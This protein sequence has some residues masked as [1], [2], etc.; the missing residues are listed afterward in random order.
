MAT[1]RYLVHDVDQSLP[2]YL[3]LG[4]T[5]LERWGPP[6]VMLERDGLTLWLSGPGTSAQRPL[7]NG[8]IPAPGGWNRLVIEVDDLDEA[9]QALRAMGAELRGA[10]VSGPGGRQVLVDDP[11]GNPIELFE[12]REA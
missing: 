6:F 5:E 2:F 10:P 9:L 7:D 4:F 8:A 11:S 1:V 3:A 12:N